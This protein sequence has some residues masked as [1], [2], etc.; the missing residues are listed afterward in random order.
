M[1]KMTPMSEATMRPIASIV[2]REIL[3]ST[4]EIART[5]VHAGKA[6][7]EKSKGKQE[8]G[9]KSK[10]SQHHEKKTG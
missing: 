5:T 7:R 1:P 10:K 9:R 6:L 3:W 2:Y 4:N 8:Q